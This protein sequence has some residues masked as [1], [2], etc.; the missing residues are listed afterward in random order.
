MMK[1]FRCVGMTPEAVAALPALDERLRASYQHCWY[2]QHRLL[3]QHY[4]PVETATAETLCARVLPFLLG[5]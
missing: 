2:E 3:Y 4:F 5:K 1:R